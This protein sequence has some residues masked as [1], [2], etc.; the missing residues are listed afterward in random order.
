MEL[1]NWIT[2]IE[3][4]GWFTIGLLFAIAEIYA[5]G[6]YL[7]WFGFA[8]FTM[9]GL[10]SFID[11]TPTETLIVFAILSAVY[12]ALGWKFYGK[13]LKKN[14][15]KNKNLNDMA[16]SYVGKVYQLNQDVVDGRAKAKVGDSFWIV[17]TEDD[18]LKQ[19]DKVRVVGVQDGVIL[20][21]EK[22]EK[23]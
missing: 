21:V 14:S 9:G 2:E 17:E 15:D 8:S 11:F 3:Y 12:S 19:G 23:K 22:Y 10:V 6:T 7:I 5:P 18:T 13:I 16:A 20:K 1:W 4:L